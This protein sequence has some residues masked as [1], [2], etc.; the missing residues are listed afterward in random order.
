MRYPCLPCFLL[1][2]SHFGSCRTGPG[3]SHDW[4][5]PVLTILLLTPQPPWQQGGRHLVPATRTKQGSKCLSLPLSSCFRHDSSAITA[6]LPRLAE[7]Q[8][9]CRSLSLIPLSFWTRASTRL[10]LVFFF[11]EEK[12]NPCYL[13]HCRVRYAVTCSRWHSRLIETKPERRESFVGKLRWLH[14]TPVTTTP[15]C[16]QWP[17]QRPFPGSAAYSFP[18]C[19]PATVRGGTL[20]GSRW[21]LPLKIHT[22]RSYRQIDFTVTE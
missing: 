1:E 11:Y 5:K 2:E 4:S 14:S 15:L 3:D 7:L 18:L 10:P 9:N 8:E 17:V 16:A 13:N 22:E 6:I 20:E 12:Q 21:S 19:N